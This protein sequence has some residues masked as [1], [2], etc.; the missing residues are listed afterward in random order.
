MSYL[1]NNCNTNVITRLSLVIVLDTL[2]LEDET[3]H[4]APS[5]AASVKAVLERFGIPSYENLVC[6]T[7]D[8]AKVNFSVAT[9]LQTDFQRFNGFIGQG[10]LPVWFDF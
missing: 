4:K 6:V 1:K 9:L 3:S 10:Y 2:P 8:G 5:Y 7:T